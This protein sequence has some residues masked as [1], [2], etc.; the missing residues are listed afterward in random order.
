MIQLII[1]YFKSGIHPEDTEE[2]KRKIYLLNTFSFVAFLFVFPLG[3]RALV[4]GDYLLS[5]FLLS[6]SISSVSNYFFIRRSARKN[7]IE[8][9]SYVMSILFFILMTYLIYSGGVENTGSLWVYALP[10]IVMF[11]LGLTKG[12]YFMLLFFIVNIFILYGL[13]VSPYIDAY[14]M[15][16]LLSLSVVTSL[17]AA[18][19]YSRENSINK[20][21]ILSQ[22]LEDIAQK[23][24]L[25][26]VLNRRGLH[27]EIESVCKRYKDEKKS[28]SILI[29]DIDHFKTI[30]D[31]HGHEAGDVTLKNVANTLQKN[32]RED[33]ILARWGGEEFL[34]LLPN[35]CKISASHVAEKIRTSVEKNT[36][37]YQDKTISITVSVGICEKNDEIYSIY[38]VIKKADENM[39]KAKQE[40]RNRV[41]F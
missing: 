36:F 27:Q 37:I 11:L 19:E 16:I 39:Y 1:D 20:L 7:K 30:N 35:T 33:D 34:V 31:T 40:G 17:A 21:F 26:E 38:D 5:F 18:Y 2:K 29:C 28:F 23:D 15:R 12:L 32:I 6:I 14:K 8:I 3:V 10:L 24:H 13:D 4:Q 22:R 41:V 9:V 25:T